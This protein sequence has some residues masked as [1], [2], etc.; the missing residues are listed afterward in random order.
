MSGGFGAAA[1]L[2]A[3]DCRDD[4]RG[5]GDS[6]DRD[7]EQAAAGAVFGVHCAL[8]PFS[9]G[10][11]VD[12]GVDCGLGAADAIYFQEK[13]PFWALIGY[14]ISR[15]RRARARSAARPR[16]SRARDP[17]FRLSHQF[18]IALG[19]PTLL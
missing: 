11:W 7:D 5:H 8:S 16:A 14:T 13:R 15:A 19:S 1:A 9:V 10:G 4:R 3:A 17:S 12:C 18:A 2:A 6:G